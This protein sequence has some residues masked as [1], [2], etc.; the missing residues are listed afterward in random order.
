[1]HF[2]YFLKNA[3]AVIEKPHEWGLAHVATHPAQLMCRQASIPHM[4]NG[5]LVA[6][7]CAEIVR[8][9]ADA[10]QWHKMPGRF[11]GGRE[12]WAGWK[13]DEQPTPTTLA[14]SHQLPGTKLEL[15]DGQKWIVPVLRKF[16][17]SDRPY[18]VYSIQLPTVLDYDADGSLRIGQVIPQYRDVWGRAMQIGD[19]LSHGVKIDGESDLTIEESIEFAGQI[20]G[21]NYHV[22][23]FEVVKL[24]L[25]TKELADQIVRLALDFDGWENQLKNL[26]SRLQSVGM[27]SES[28]GELAV[29]E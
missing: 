13:T 1:M 9:D 18:P 25:L 19:F 14:R 23:I 10:Q 27:N 29:P 8:Y 15:L 6:Q 3:P 16:Q 21:L 7:A 22:S 12:V 11:C 5:T 24:G 26:A 28:G 20:L 17:E 4:G 2:L